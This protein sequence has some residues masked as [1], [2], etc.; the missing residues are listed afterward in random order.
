MYAQVE[1]RIRQH[2]DQAFGSALLV[3]KSGLALGSALFLALRW[4]N[5]SFPVS[6]FALGLAAT[7]DYMRLEHN[8]LA[9]NKTHEFLQWLIEYRRGKAIVEVHGR[10]FRKDEYKKHFG[11]A[12]AG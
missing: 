6:L 11:E 2:Y 10:N 7:L 12:D 4:R 9:R 3:P 5:S 8:G 1:P